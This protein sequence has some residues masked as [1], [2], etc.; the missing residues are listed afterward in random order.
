M[1]NGGSGV[2]AG[3]K[4]SIEI[5]FY[6]QGVRCKERIK[7]PPTPRNLRYCENLKG[8]IEHEIA[9]GQFNY[10]DHFPGSKRA[11]LLSR[12]PGDAK[13]ISDHLETWLAKVKDQVKA[14]TYRGYARVVRSHLIPAF[15]ALHLSELKRKDV[16][17][18]AANHGGTTKTIRN[19]ISPLRVALNDAVEDEIIE[20]SP[21]A[22]WR[23]KRGRRT[24]L[25]RDKIDPFTL[26]ERDAILAHLS[27]QGKNFIQFAFWTGLRT[28]ELCA[29]DWGDIDFLRGVVVV[30]R[31]LT[32]AASEPEEP[33][34]KAGFREVKLLAP[35]LAALK[36]QKA[37]TYLKGAEVFQ[38]PPTGERW[39]G[40][41]PIRKTLWQPAL[42]RGGIRYR[43]PYQTRHTFA[44]MMLMAGEHVMWVA[45]QMGHTDWGF[46]ARTYARFMPDDMPDAGKKAEQAWTTPP[47]PAAA[48]G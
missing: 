13:L 36:A 41:Q 21:L 11:S 14:S 28:S 6:Y 46:T 25:K 30:S 33:K 18:W 23:I 5:D 10:V 40:D 1:G 29:L 2:R 8:R 17:D 19:I 7:L 42:I 34:T 35:A 24:G 32:Q 9:T 43:N 44:S 4:S 31:A 3:S 26:E 27:G 48:N 47:Q 45:Q 38:N 20:A 22:G 16:K 15:G 37:F 39:V 12:C